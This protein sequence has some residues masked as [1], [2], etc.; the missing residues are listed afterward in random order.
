MLSIQHHGRRLSWK[1]WRWVNSLRSEKRTIFQLRKT[2]TTTS[3]LPS[4]YLQ[5]NAMTKASFSITS[6]SQIKRVTV[7]G[8]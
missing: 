2:H 1:S 4:S 6:I 7:I 8:A 5:W 3:G